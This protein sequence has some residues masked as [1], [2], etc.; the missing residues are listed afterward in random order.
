MRRKGREAGKKILGEIRGG[1]RL[2]CLSM[3]VCED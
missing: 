3:C 1:R 2:R